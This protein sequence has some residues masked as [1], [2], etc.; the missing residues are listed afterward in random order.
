[1]TLTSEQV[2][3]LLTDHCYRVLNNMNH[4]DLLNCAMQM[5]KESFD[6]NPGMGDTDVDMLM[7]DIFIAEDDDEDSVYEFLIGSGIE[8]EIAEGLVSSHNE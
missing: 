5:M 6:V 3:N 2:D 1:M 4:D 7:R 8:D